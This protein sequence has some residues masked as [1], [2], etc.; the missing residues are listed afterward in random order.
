[1]NSGSPSS[2][3]FMG[4]H[5][6]PYIQKVE[7]AAQR[8][9]LLLGLDLLW[10]YCFPLL[11]KAAER[12]E[13]DSWFALGDAFNLGRGTARD[14]NAAIKWFQR[15]AE[16]GHARSMVRLGVCLSYPESPAG[17]SRAVEWFLKAADKGDSWGMMRLGFCNRDGRGVPV[18]YKKAVEWFVKAAEAG[19]RHARVAAGK[20]YFYHLA[21]PERALRWL[22]KAAEAGCTEGYF[23][24]ALLYDNRKSRVFN[25]VA[26]AR[27]YHVVAELGGWGAPEAMLALSRLYRDGVGVRR[28]PKVAR[29]WL[30]RLV[31]TT[32]EARPRKKAVK[33]LNEIEGDLL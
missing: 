23:E 21:D 13:L 11:M 5:L 28:S 25:P 29:M 14:R 8:A 4:T 32:K 31:A 19:D 9:N 16:S 6:F 22:L 7:D 10:D 24:I 18:D 1:M 26:A 2:R 12:S 27:W 20:V 15:A 33:L 3:Y 30:Q 17:L